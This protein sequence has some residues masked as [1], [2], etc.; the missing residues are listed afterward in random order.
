MAYREKMRPVDYTSP[1]KDSLQEISTTVEEGIDCLKNK[2]TELGNQVVK[3]GNRLSGR[4]ELG[5]DKTAE[6]MESTSQSLDKAAQYVKN[7]T[8]GSMAADLYHVALKHP[9]KTLFFFGALFLLIGSKRQK[10][11]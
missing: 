8:P 4:I 5:K 7:K 11:T 2:A 9:G 1:E 10:C 3:L 6:A